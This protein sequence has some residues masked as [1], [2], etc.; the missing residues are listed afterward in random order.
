[1]TNKIDLRG[2]RIS[3]DERVHA[4]YEDLVSRSSES[5]EDR[6]FLTMKDVFIVA[7]CLG[8]KYGQYKELERS[9][10]VFNGD[11]FDPDLEVPILCAIA[12]NKNK[13]LDD[14]YDN[15]KIIRHCQNYANGGVYVL[16]EKIESASGLGKLYRIIDIFRSDNIA[17][18]TNK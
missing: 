9:R 1:M 15:E 17:K 14:L 16:Q 18:E 7:T 8:S 13:N 11:L 4:I 5:V 3:I 6:P 10:Q 2:L 12:Y